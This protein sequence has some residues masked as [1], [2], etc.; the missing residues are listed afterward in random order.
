[1][2][3]NIENAKIICPDCLGQEIDFCSTC[4]NQGIVLF[5]KQEQ[6]LLLDNISINPFCYQTLA[7]LL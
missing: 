3:Q 4:E 6:M 7:F 2:S 5:K 1:M